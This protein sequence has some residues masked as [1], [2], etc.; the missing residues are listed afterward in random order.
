MI[1][2][3]LLRVSVALLLVGL[4]FGIAMGMTQDFALAP[5]HAHLNLVGFVIP[6]LAGLYYRVVPQSAHGMLATVQA[7]LA[8]IGGVMFPVGVAAVVGIGLQYEAVAIIG[9]LIVLASATLFAIIVFCTSGARA[10]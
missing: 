10:A 7:A 4:C 5:A 9:A 3:L 8:I 6:F 1:S 2:S